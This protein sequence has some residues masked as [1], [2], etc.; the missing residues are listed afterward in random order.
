[1]TTTSA[2]RSLTFT[3]LPKAETNPLVLRRNEIV[4]RLD[5]QKRLATDPNHV[6]VIKTKAGEKQLKVRPMWKPL[7][8]GSLAVFLN[9]GFKPIEW[10]PGWTTHS[11]VAFRLGSLRKLAEGTKNHDFERDL[12]IEER[13]AE[14]GILLTRYLRQGWNRLPRLLVHCFWIAI[15]GAYWLLADYGR[16]AIRPLVGL[17]AS[18]FIFHVA[19]TG[20]LTPRGTSIEDTFKRAVTAFTIANDA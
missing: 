19:Y 2:L 20:V 12:Y 7:E 18:V 5:E 3:I 6:K 17:T 14:R 13:K 8:D 11:I 10:A 4:K 15:T 9:V 16:S 1:M